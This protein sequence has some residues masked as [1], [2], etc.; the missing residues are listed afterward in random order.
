MMVDAPGSSEAVTALV[1]SPPTQS[2]AADTPGP[3]ANAACH[4]LLVSRLP[5]CTSIDQHMWPIQLQC[6]IAERE[7]P[8]VTCIELPAASKTKFYRP[9]CSRDNIKLEP[10]VT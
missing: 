5:G 8:A 4:F 6:C 3:P 9:R 10:S 2:R 7:C 1:A